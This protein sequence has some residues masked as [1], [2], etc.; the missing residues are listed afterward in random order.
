M[1]RPHSL[2]VRD[3]FCHADGTANSEMPSMRMTFALEATDCGSRLTTTTFVNGFDELEQLRPDLPLR[4][5]GGRERR[6]PRVH[7]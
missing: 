3:G 6:D 5:A 7:R 4:V 1:P 2:A